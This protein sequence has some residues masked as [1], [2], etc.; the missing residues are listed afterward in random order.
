MGSPFGYGVR[1]PAVMAASGL[2]AAEVDGPV[3]YRSGRGYQRGPSV[4]RPWR[5]YF[6]F[7]VEA[8]TLVVPAEGA[9]GAEKL[10]AR[11]DST[12]STSGVAALAGSRLALGTQKQ[13][14]QN[15]PGQEQS[16][17]NSSEPM[18]SRETETSAPTAE[19]GN[20]STT[21]VQAPNEG[22]AL[23]AGKASETAG[24]APHLKGSSRKKALEA[25][26]YTTRIRV[27]QGSETAS[28]VWLGLR[29]GAESGRD[30]LDFAQVP[31]IGNGLRLWAEE[32][33]AGRTVPHAG[34]FKPP[35]RGASSGESSRENGRAWKLVLVNPA[36]GKR[37]A[38]LGFETEGRLPK[39]M[40][41]Y[42]LDLSTERRVAPGQRLEL[43]AGER[44]EL[45]VIVGT[46][47]YAKEKS[48]GIELTTFKNE[49]RGNYPNPFSKQTTIA[50][51]L[52]KKQ[53]VTVEVYNVLGQRVRTLVRGKK[54][55][56]GLHEVAW[57][58]ESRYGTPVGSGVYFYRIRAE[59][60]Q[61]T[62]K[63]VL[64]R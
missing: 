28:Q 62:R 15:R 8:D 13:A 56:A 25:L 26:P 18:R 14:V 16:G 42:V 5:G 34:S 32:K 60:F 45:K 36:D 54:Q 43:E 35:V 21:P 7:S 12:A 37:E 27:W 30:E 19:T 3:G 4:L 1:W 48:E 55:A 23:T 20:Q 61:E 2:E 51:T 57:E 31:P 24:M 49:L 40:S 10:E 29:Q 53:E 59:G 41:R 22:E 38:R 33:V 44:R 63:M 17:P 64:V 50:Y 6:V 39:G 46:E 52:E 47:G 58:G 11:N 9:S